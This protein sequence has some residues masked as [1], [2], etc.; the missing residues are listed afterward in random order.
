MSMQ[1]LTFKIPIGYKAKPITV[2]RN[3]GHACAVNMATQNYKTLIGISE[4][5]GL[6]SKLF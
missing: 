6:T 4:Q 5:Y 3:F 1:L 2:A